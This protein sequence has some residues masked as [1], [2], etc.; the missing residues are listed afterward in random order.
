[1]CNNS[2]YLFILRIKQRFLLGAV[3]SEKN[4]MY[5]TGVNYVN[6]FMNTCCPAFS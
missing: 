3:W 5:L 6:D 4:D 1:M 2:D